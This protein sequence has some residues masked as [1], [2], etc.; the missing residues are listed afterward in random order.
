MPREVLRQYFGYSEFRNGQE[1]LIQAQ[2]SGRDAFGVMPTGGGKSICYQIPAMMLPGITL[3][4]SPLISLMKDQVMA[5]K[6]AGIPAAFLNSSLS[7]EQIRKVYSNLRYGM[8]KIVYIAPER[9]LTDGFLAIAQN[10]NIALLAV[11]EA[12][13]ISQWGQDFRPSYLKIVE[14]MQRLP[15]R[16]VVSAF[17][18]TATEQVQQDVVRILGLR[19]PLRVVTGFDRPN[20]YYEVLRPE[21]KQDALLAFLEERSGK[22]GII[23]CAT[24]RETESVCQMLQEHNYSALCYHAGMPDAERQ[25]NQED[26][27]YDRCRIMVATNAFGMGIDKSNVSFVLHYNM[28]KSLEAYYQ[29]AGRA[30]RDGEQADCYLL[31]A[32]RDVQTARFLIQSGGENDE[33]TSEERANVVAQDMMRLEAMVGYCQTVSCLRGYILDYFGEEHTDNCRNCGNCMSRTEVQDIT[34]QAQI[35]LSCIQRI[36]K[37]LNYSLGASA[38]VDVLRGRKRKRIRELGLD[39]LST[40]GML[41]NLS[42]VQLHLILEA[43][44]DQGYIRT[45][46]EHKGLVLLQKAGKVLFENEAVTMRIRMKDA[47]TLTSILKPSAETPMDENLLAR[48]KQ[49]RIALAKQELVP[50]Y[51]IFTNASLADMARKKPRT[52]EEFLGISG[53]GQSKAARYGRPFLKEI[54]AYLDGKE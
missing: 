19:D 35:V 31:Y 15:V 20:L 46:M 32:K 21:N 40:Y 10:L 2:L 23:Y 50:A 7:G 41:S 17:T 52:M 34:R 4:V 43:L 51:I 27:V 54:T 14:F 36:Y 48:L 53:V 22:S 25:R 33:M 42:S 16:P 38:V 45:D 30:G 11:D 44:E 37:K 3:V 26:F 29:E 28:A 49:L 18:A 5:L 12:H 1:A 39:T 8:Y 13:C 6:N 9:L 24:R 47:V